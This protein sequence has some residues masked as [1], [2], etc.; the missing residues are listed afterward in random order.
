M[1][2]HDDHD[3]TQAMTPQRWPPSVFATGSDPDPRFSLANQR[4]LLAW[5]RTALAFVLASAVVDTAPVDIPP[6]LRLIATLVLSA[7]GTSAALL[8]WRSW[9]RSER[10]LRRGEPLPS[11]GAAGAV[12]AI[13]VAATAIVV[14]VVA[15]QRTA[16]RG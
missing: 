11:P 3:A 6:I 10:A 8:G 9:R 13:A 5:V 2:R 1:T 15:L 7:A 16:G 4:T 14:V 12:L